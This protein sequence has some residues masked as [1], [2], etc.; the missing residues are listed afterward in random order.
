MGNYKFAKLRGIQNYQQWQRQMTNALM[1][2]GHWILITN[3]IDPP[4]KVEDTVLATMTWKEKREYDEDRRKHFTKDGVAMVAIY[5]MCNHS[6]QQILE[7]TWTAK[8]T[9]DRLKKRYEPSESHKKWMVLN[10]LEDLDYGNFK[11]VSKYRNRIEIITR[12]FQELG[13]TW[14]NL[15]DFKIERFASSH[16]ELP[17]SKIWTVKFLQERV[18]SA[19]RSSK[20]EGSG[21]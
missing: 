11:S 10:R 4:K 8:E 6:V 5:N 19:F 3:A 14:E 16:P 13:I 9:W 17:D 1:I 20:S 21:D 7:P 2:E 18:E 12:E 15:M